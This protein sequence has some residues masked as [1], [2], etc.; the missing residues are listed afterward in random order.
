MSSFVGLFMMFIN[1]FTTL[2]HECAQDALGYV[3]AHM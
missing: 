2:A 1:T 3:H